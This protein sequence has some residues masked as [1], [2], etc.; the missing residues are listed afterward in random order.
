M[1]RMSELYIEICDL[2]NEGY[3]PT[4]IATMLGLPLDIVYNVLFD[5]VEEPYE[6]D[7]YDDSMDGD[8]D[9]S[10]ISAGFGTNEDYGYYGDE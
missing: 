3:K 1:G 7:C 8:F 4:S 9:S 5:D 10:M 2:H 6:P